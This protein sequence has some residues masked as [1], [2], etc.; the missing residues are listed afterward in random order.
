ML[1]PTVQHWQQRLEWCMFS[2]E[3]RFYIGIQDERVRVIRRREERRGIQFMY[4]AVG[5]MIWSDIAWGSSSKVPWTPNVPLVRWWNP[6]SSAAGKLSFS[7]NARLHVARI[8]LNRFEDSHVN[9]FEWLPISTDLSLIEHVGRKLMKLAYT[10]QTLEILRHKL[11]VT[12]H[13]IP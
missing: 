8:L 1:P 11:Q 6:L 9:I 7:T 4:R 13:T 3:S 10:M 12:W 2:D 5:V